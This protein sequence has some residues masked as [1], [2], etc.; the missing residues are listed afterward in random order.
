[1]ARTPRALAN[2]KERDESQGAAAP[3][4][5]LEALPRAAARDDRGSW[6][7]AIHQDWR[8]T[9]HLH[10]ADAGAAAYDHA[11]AAFRAKVAEEKAR[12]GL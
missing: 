5:V 9:E 2:L 3:K 6:K 12:R 10:R 7:R 11:V 8:E 4:H 1:M